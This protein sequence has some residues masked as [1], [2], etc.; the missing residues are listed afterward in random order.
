MNNKSFEDKYELGK[1][2]YILLRGALDNYRKF[3]F[4][5]LISESLPLLEISTSLA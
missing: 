4:Y 3:L 1:P 2:H 5:L